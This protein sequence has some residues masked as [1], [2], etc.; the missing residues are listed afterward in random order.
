MVLT[1]SGLLFILQIW[2]PRLNEFSLGSGILE[3]DS[4][5][6]VREPRFGQAPCWTATWCS[7]FWTPF[8]LQIWWPETFHLWEVEDWRR[9]WNHG[10]WLGIIGTSDPYADLCRWRSRRSLHKFK[11]T[12]FM[13]L[14]VSWCFY[15]TLQTSTLVMHRATNTPFMELL[16]SW[17]FYETIQTSIYWLCIEPI[18]L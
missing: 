9:Y 17:C 15:E 18:R 11:T 10:F 13:E 12:P 4:V 6:K 14:L 2:Y 16:V 3:L 8:Y 1:I 5:S 7:P